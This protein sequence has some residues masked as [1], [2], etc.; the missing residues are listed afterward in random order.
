M[1]QPTW[2]AASPPIGL[3]R[4]VDG[5]DRGNRPGR[6]NLRLYE[7]G[8]IVRPS[9]AAGGPQMC[10]MIRYSCGLT[11]RASTRLFVLAK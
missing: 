2:N 7:A 1:V 11:Q 9:A 4:I 3:Y 6:C 8:R 10:H 5:T